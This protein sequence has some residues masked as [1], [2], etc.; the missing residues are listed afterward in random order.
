MYPCPCCGNVTLSER[1]PGTFEICP[2]CRWEDDEA[3]FRDPEMRGGANDASLEQARLNFEEI[4]ASAPEFVDD[5]RKPKPEE[6]PLTRPS[7]A[8][9]DR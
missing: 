6:L 3:Q 1:P 5:V 9:F 8:P 7:D 2:L 4:G